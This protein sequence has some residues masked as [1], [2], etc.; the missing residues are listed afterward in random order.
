MQVSLSKLKKRLLCIFIE[1]Q[2]AEL[3]NKIK[4]KIF[5]L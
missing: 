2:K 3:Q 4:I 5:Q 1:S